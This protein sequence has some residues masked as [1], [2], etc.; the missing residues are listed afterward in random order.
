MEVVERSTKSDKVIAAI[1]AVKTSEGDAALEHRSIA[2]DSAGLPKIVLMYHSKSDDI[3][4]KIQA[5]AL[6]DQLRTAQTKVF[7]DV[8]DGI[9]HDI[10]WQAHYQIVERSL[11]NLDHK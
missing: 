1:T 10:P 5:D 9:G 3:A 8:L 6:N 11:K 7:F 2:W 4:P